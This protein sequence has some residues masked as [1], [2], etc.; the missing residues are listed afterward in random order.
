[1]GPGAVW[2]RLLTPIIT[3][4]ANTPAQRAV[5]AA[6]F[7]NGVSGSLGDGWVFMNSDLTAHIS[8]YPTTE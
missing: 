7:C 8:R 4:H 1:M 2:I 6:D 5:A 3:G